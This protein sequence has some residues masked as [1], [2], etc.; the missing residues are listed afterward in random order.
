MVDVLVQDGGYACI[1]ASGVAP[2]RQPG[3]YCSGFSKFGDTVNLPRMN[4]VNLCARPVAIHNLP[5]KWTSAYD[6]RSGGL[7]SGTAQ[8]GSVALDAHPHAHW[9]ARFSAYSDMQ[10]LLGSEHACIFFIDAPPPDEVPSASSAMLYSPVSANMHI[11]LVEEESGLFFE[12]GTMRFGKHEFAPMFERILNGMTLFDV[13]QSANHIATF[14]NAAFGSFKLDRC[15]FG[16]ADCHCIL[17]AEFRVC[18]RL[19]PLVD[20]SS[21]VSAFSVGQSG[22]LKF[23]VTVQADKEWHIAMVVAHAEP[24]SPVSESP[25]P[26]PWTLEQLV[27]TCR[28]PCADKVA[29]IYKMCCLSNDTQD[30]LQ[31]NPCI[32]RMW[33]AAIDH[34]HAEFDYFVK[35]ARGK[36]SAPEPVQTVHRLRSV[37]AA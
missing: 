1:R 30:F 28:D 16:Q 23:K 4:L 8:G 26:G 15:A 35:A 3:Y 6:H 17:P 21:N 25:A 31:K 7:I 13:C 36:T 34:G 18:E 32:L 33:N 24:Q 2:E 11:V 20:L 5:A 37:R 29:T 12:S 27:N 14:F 9:S 10:L 19:A 22:I